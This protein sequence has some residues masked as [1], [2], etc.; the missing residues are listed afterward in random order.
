M[1]SLA[2]FYKGLARKLDPLKYIHLDG[3]RYMGKLDR[4]DQ[5]PSDAKS[6][7]MYEISGFK[8]VYTADNEWI[9]C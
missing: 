1:E 2:K 4:Y 9:K 6:G 7:D 8:Y 5:L 3:M